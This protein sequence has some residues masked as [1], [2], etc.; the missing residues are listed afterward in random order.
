MEINVEIVSQPSTTVYQQKA[1]ATRARRQAKGLYRKPTEAQRNAFIMMMQ[2]GGAHLSKEELT[3]L[4][5]H[6]Y[7][8]AGQRQ[9]FAAMAERAAE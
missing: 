3:L 7:L 2:M 6:P 8:T 9:G 4:S 1:Q 5:T